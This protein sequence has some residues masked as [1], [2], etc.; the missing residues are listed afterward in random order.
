M[1][2]KY[3]NRFDIF[4][5]LKRKNSF[6]TMNTILV[7][8]TESIVHDLEVDNIEPYIFEGQENGWE[9]KYL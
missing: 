6:S 7:I 5:S 9:N 4:S 1:L 2:A 3:S 8:Q